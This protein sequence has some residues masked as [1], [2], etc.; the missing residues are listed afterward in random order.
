M[1]QNILL[2]GKYINQPMELSVFISIVAAVLVVAAVIAIITPMSH[3]ETDTL[4]NVTDTLPDDLEDLGPIAGMRLSKTT[5]APSQEI[6]NNQNNTFQ[7]GEII[8]RDKTGRLLTRQDFKEATFNGQLR[9]HYAQYFSPWNMF[10][11]D[12]K[13]FASTDGPLELHQYNIVFNQPTIVRDIV[14]E[15]RQDCC[16]GRLEGVQLELYN[17]KNEVVY[18]HVLTADMQQVIR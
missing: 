5:I 6:L 8:I 18:R 17:E 3:N 4:S 14:I 16:Q 15:N 2:C 9:E 10:D 11:G 1:H 7:V 13:T 12:N